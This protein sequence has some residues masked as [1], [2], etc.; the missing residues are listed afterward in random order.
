M[1][2]T[3]I[4][5]KNLS[6]GRVASVAASFLIGKDQVNFTPNAVVKRKVIVENL[7]E[8]RITGSKLQGKKYFSHSS[9][10]GS[11]KSITLG[12]KFKKNPKKTLEDMVKG[13]LPVN[14]LRNIRI[15]NLIIFVGSENDK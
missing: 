10:I 2:K 12:E 13:M 8:V 3:K 6:I 1:E 4:N 14:K 11:M 15:K 7:G 5:A 9:Y